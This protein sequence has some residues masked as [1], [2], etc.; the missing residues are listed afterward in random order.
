MPSFRTSARA[1][2]VGGAAGDGVV[3]SNGKA[4][5]KVNLSQASFGAQI[6]GQTYSELIVFQNEET[7][8]RFKTSDMTFSAQVSAVAL[9]SG[10][11]QNA[12]YTDGVMVITAAKGGLMAE[13]AVGGQKFHFK[14]FAEPLPAS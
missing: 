13:A 9:Q 8:T 11:S 1:A 3:F 5:G 10:V 12:K 6:G 2:V 14:P 4:I 7:L